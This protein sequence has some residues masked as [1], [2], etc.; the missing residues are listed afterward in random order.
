VT[1]NFEGGPERY[2]AI[3][4]SD[5]TLA[6]MQLVEAQSI[7]NVTPWDT[8]GSYTSVAALGG[9]LYAAVA[10][11]IKGASVHLLELFDQAVTL[12]AAQLFDDL[13]DVPAVYG[14]TTVHVV[15]GNYHLGT[16]PVML[17]DP[18]PPGPYWVGLDYTTRIETLPPVLDD[19]EGSHVGE[20]MRI[21]Q[22]D[23]IALDSARFRAQGYELTAYLVTEPLD[24]PPPLR[25]GAQRIQFL[26]WRRE[27]TITITQPDP[28]PLTVLGIRSTVAF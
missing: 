11:T 24:Q 17:E 18:P 16:H 12:D 10:R 9:S 5:G 1:S 7:R 4:N 13:A 26:G 22:T 27:P 8:T 3:R 28:L 19:G 20:L 15:V 25:S 14:S 2:A 23:V 21:V 6:M